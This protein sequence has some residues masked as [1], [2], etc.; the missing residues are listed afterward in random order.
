[1][2][3]K[4]SG[5]RFDEQKHEY[6]LGNKQLSGIT[7][8][9]QRQLFKDEYSCCPTSLLEQASVYGSQ[10]HKSIQNLITDFSHDGSI[11][12]EDFVNL[13]KHE[14]LTTV[15]SEYNVTDESHWS[16][17]IDVVF[18]N[19]DTHFSLGDIKTC[20]LTP[21]ALQRAR[22]QLSVYAYLFEHQ[23]PKCK[24]DELIILNIR[25]KETR[26]GEFS[27]I[28]K[29]VKVDR[30]P[31]DIVRD[32]LDT[33]LRGEQFVNPFDIPEEVSSQLSHIIELI[34]IKKKAEEELNA[35]KKSI[36]DTMLF[37]DVRNWVTPEVRLTRKQDSVRTS[38]D[39]Q[40]FK[41]GHPEISDYD[42]YMKTSAVAGSLVIT[43]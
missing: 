38:F 9:I 29:A 15:R 31:S 19:S 7:E 28:C 18:E 20:K 10:V 4:E 25:N 5:V 37:L 42:N 2:K 33:D 22:W 39:L 3:L 30:I 23:N 8:M 16:S 13:T 34:N 26:I 27:H 43:V 14:G 36:L 17:N 21:T 24:V 1:M 12:V 41:K 6:W 32:L 40:S 35:L 11:E